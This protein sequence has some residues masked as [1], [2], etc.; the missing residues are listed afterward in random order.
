MEVIERT[1]NP[2]QA[3]RRLAES[4]LR[5]RYVLT[6]LHPYTSASG[7]PIFWRIRAEHETEPKWIRP[8]M[9]DASG[10]FVL[11]EP[12]APS[13]GKPLYRLHML[14]QNPSAAVIVTEGEAK[15][16]RLERI[17]CTVTTSGSSSSADGADWSPLRGRRV[18]I[19]PDND[20]AGAKYAQA[21]AAKLQGIA[22]EVRIIDVSR[23]SLPPKGDAVEWL[24]AHPGATADAVL[25]LPVLPPAS[26]A[27]VD[28]TETDALPPL[29]ISGAIERAR[30]LLLP[31]HNGTDA[32][33]PLDMLGPLA[34]AARDLAEG[35]QV[36]PAMAGQS[37]LAAVTDRHIPATSESA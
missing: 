32:P 3:A 20:A 29:P 35:A 23:L 6:A 14:A 18:L 11:G 19:W 7:A 21:V 24:E 34:E 30:A 15:A 17:G 13:T 12:P 8:M 37:L 26:P 9:Q 33:Y 5:K 10:A 36:S 27:S 4:V 25:A 31:E 1:E 28:S 22:A 16:G 2:Q